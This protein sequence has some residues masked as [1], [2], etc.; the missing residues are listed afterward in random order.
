MKQRTIAIFSLVFA[1]IFW[2]ATFVIVKD[3][4][5]GYGVFSFLMLRFTIGA[6]VLLPFAATKLN[7]KT[8][9]Q[10]GL[11]GIAL[12]LGF[13]WQTLG[14]RYTTAS[15]SGLLTS[16]FLVFAILF[17]QLFF[18]V[19]VPVKVW[20][21]VP[22]A[23]IG[24]GILAGGD[25]T[26]LS[27]GT[28]EFYSLLCAVAFG[29]QV[30][31]LGRTGK[32]TSSV[33]MTFVLLAV[34]AVLSGVFAFFTEPF[35]YPT[36]SVWGGIIICGVICSSLCFLL[37]TYAQK[38]LDTTVAAFIMSCEPIFAVMFGVIFH[39]DTFTVMQS[40]GALIMLTATIIISRLYD[41][42]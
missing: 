13:Y 29:V 17:N 14:L 3:S 2:G 24:L 8:V 20:C 7:R 1:T 18:K 19:R 31:L 10:G 30:A 26:S 12:F 39:H 40:C 9:W 34:V 6:A 4:V 41:K 21:I 16:L 5:S 32:E 36:K 22:I 25:M 15:M 27:S 28:G 23:L 33:A 11:I 35:A 42:N 38:R 37:Q